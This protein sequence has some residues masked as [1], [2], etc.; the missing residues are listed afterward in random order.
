MAEEFLN[1]FR[2][3]DGSAGSG[4]LGKQGVG[5]RILAYN[6]SDIPMTS[7]GFERK[8]L[9]VVF[10]VVKACD[11]GFS[12]VPYVNDPKTGKTK[13][14]NGAMGTSALRSMPADYG[15]DSSVAP[16]TMN[17]MDCW[18]F[19]IVEGCPKDKDDRNEEY[20]WEVV[21]GMAIRLVIF[22]LLCSVL[23][24]VKIDL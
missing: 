24:L 9:S 11:P 22:V 6:N 17:L 23:F 12:K 14:G 20:R 8:N 13:V 15:V 7:E 4:A 21:P 19:G 3:R 5:F 16:M 1:N 18:P 2:V 10:T